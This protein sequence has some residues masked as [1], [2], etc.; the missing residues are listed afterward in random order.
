[1]MALSIKPIS[2]FQTDFN[3]IKILMQ[4]FLSVKTI[5]AFFS[6]SFWKC[7]QKINLFASKL[8]SRW[9]WLWNQCLGFKNGYLL[10]NDW[11]HNGSVNF[12]AYTVFSHQIITK[13]A[14][15]NQTFALTACST[16]NQVSSRSHSID[17]TVQCCFVCQGVLSSLCCTGAHVECSNC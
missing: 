13:A 5:C 16:V 3:C 7:V 1:M 8:T 10:N 14:D 12:Y 4:D 11:P 9:H 2:R 15:Q 6:P 17:I